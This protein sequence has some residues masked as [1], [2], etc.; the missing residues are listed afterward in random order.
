MK[1][2][3]SY[4]NE[5]DRFWAN[6]RKSDGC[7]EWTA[8]RMKGGYGRI[9]KA[10]GMPSLAH[11]FS[12]EIHFGPI[13]EGRH[14][15]HH[16]DNPPCIRPDHLFLGTHRENHLDA[17]RKGR[18]GA[19]RHPEKYRDN[20]KYFPKYS[21]EKHWKTTLTAKNVLT[22]RR[23]YDAGDATQEELAERFG[24]HA[25]RSLTL[26]RGRGGFIYPRRFPTNTDSSATSSS[27]ACAARP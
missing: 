9:R 14:V 8:Y 27:L 6:V 16:C 24:S 10:N 7:W 2:L 18:A 12:W 15:C 5:I 11:R 21:G 13:P 25:T 4:A 3:F 23:E 1:H 26:L 17:S 19:Q 22:I 20:A